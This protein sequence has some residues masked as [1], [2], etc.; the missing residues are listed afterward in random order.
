MKTLVSLAL[1]F[2]FLF[3]SSS[4]F[5]TELVDIGPAVGS[6]VD[7]IDVLDSTG[8]PQKIKS[9]AGS[10]GLVLVLF[11]SADWCPYCKK[12]LI[13]AG[14]WQKDLEKRGFS[15]AAISYDSPKVLA[16]FRDV[17]NIN[18]PLLSDQNQKTF[19]AFGVL[20]VEHKKGSHGFGIPYP[21]VI[22]FDAEGKAKYKYFYQGYK[23]RASWDLIDVATR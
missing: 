9:L 2:C 21:G 8:Q 3:S 15:L 19:S 18:Y 5:A 13:E 22:V 17:K 4:V 11:R 7:E 10:K 1:S 16:K 6:I 23:K 14:T 12:H 20:N